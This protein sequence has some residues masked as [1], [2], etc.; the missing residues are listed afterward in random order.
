MPLGRSLG[1]LGMRCVV[2]SDLLYP[3][4]PVLCEIQPSS[5][6]GFYQVDLLRPRPFFDLVLALERHSYAGRFLEVHEPRDMIP[7]GKTG[8]LTEPVLVNAAKKISGYPCV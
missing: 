6:D 5:V 7:A 8:N 4:E 3:L 2:R 1:A